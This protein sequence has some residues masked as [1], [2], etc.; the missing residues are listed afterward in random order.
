MLRL[1]KSLTG[2]VFFLFAMTALPANA[3]AAEPVRIE[4]LTFNSG[5]MA[6]RAEGIELEG[7]NLSAESMEALL[8]GTDIA[9]QAKALSTLDATIWGGFV[10]TVRFESMS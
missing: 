5:G 4:N 8:H 2:P 3:G 7:V 10:R 9:A 1:F 6:Y